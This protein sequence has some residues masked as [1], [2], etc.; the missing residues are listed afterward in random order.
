MKTTWNVTAWVSMPLMLAAV[1]GPAPASATGNDAVLY[2]LNEQAQF[3]ENNHRVATSGLEGKARRGTPLCPEGLMAY[4]EVLFA[5]LGIT[6]KDA[7][8]CTVVAFGQSDLDLATFGGT[9]G[10]EFYVVVNSDATNLA[11]APELVIMAGAFAGTIQVFDP[12]GVIIDILPGSTFSPTAIL[13]G[14]PGGLPSPATFTGKFRLPF[15][16]HHIAVYKKDSGR[17]VPV[18]AD[19][20]ALGDATVRVEIDFD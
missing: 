12:D 14:F 4:A 17:P 9:I 20:R 16:V 15:K 18:R 5:V 19:E 2:E 10:G 7:S 8:R 13:P 6:V 1:M 3:T 11:D